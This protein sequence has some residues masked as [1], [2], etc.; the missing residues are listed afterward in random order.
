[1]GKAVPITSFRRAARP[2]ASAVA[3]FVGLDDAPAD[4]PVTEAPS[5]EAQQASPPIAPVTAH[6]ADQD[7]PARPSKK[8]RRKTLVRTDGREL[9]KQTFYLDAELSHRL[10]VT[11][12]ANQYDLSEAIEEA[13]GLWLKKKG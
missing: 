10:M 13:V 11:C 4:T 2:D 1:M 7:P 5:N 9:R 3:A 6:T 8:W 12:A